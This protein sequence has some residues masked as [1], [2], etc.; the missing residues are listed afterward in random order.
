[1]STNIR[2]KALLVIGAN[3]NPFAEVEF[4]TTKCVNEIFGKYCFGENV[5]RERLSP[6][7]FKSLQETIRQGKTLDSGIA[8]EVAAAML[9][10]ALELGVTHFTHWF[11][12]MTG[13][14]AEKHDC[15]IEP[16]GDGLPIAKFR[17]GELIRGEPDASSFPS[18]G[19]R[20]T[21]EARGYTAW[22]PTSPAFVLKH[23]NGA[24]LVIPTI[25]VSWT[26]EALDKK[27]PLLRSGAALQEQALR[28]LRLFGNKTANRIESTMGAEQEYFLVDRRLAALRPDLL[29]T[30]RTL[31]GAK[32]P[33]GQ[34]LEDNYFG[35]IPE[36]VLKFMTD[37]EKELLDLGVPIKTRH[38]EVAP[39]Q[40]ELAPMF[41]TANLATDHQMLIMRTLKSVAARH[42]FLCVLHEKPFA[43]VNGSGKHNNWSLGTDEGE[44]LLEPG[45]TPGENAQFLVFCTAVLRAVHKY[46]HLLRM[47]VCGA[48]NDHRLGANEAPPAIIS[49]FLGGALDEV[50]AQLA[51]GSLTP[52]SKAAPLEIGVT[53]LPPISRHSGDRNRT[54]PFA[55]TGNKFEFRAVGSSQNPAGST[56]VI[57]TI[58]AESLDYMATKLE[59]AVA[60]G[61]DFKAAVRNLV[62]ETVKEH[63]DI[64]F[65]GDCYS[66]AWKEEAAKRGLPNLVSTVDC[67]PHINSK[68][69]I[70]LF[71]KYKVYSDV[72]LNSR[73]E[74]IGDNY[75]TI[76]NI[77]SSTAVEVASTLILPAA[78]RYKESL[79]KTATTSPQK[80]LLDKLDGQI[81]AL[82]ISLETL[83]AKKAGFPD[84][85]T[86]ERANYCR[87]KILP[88]MLELRKAVDALEETVD[89]DLWPLP[90]YTEMLFAY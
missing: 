76:I 44:N 21:F 67:L 65:S 53:L 36:R 84:G 88:A 3:K 54:S 33:R 49:V 32:P 34:E 40:F 55:F 90:T 27:T 48:G 70:A 19:L 77:E 45:D 78:F 83:R 17:G 29:V 10:W 35:A 56:T 85:E 60:K 9:K 80:G 74:I 47:S 39:G 86:Q 14:T 58:V 24:T 42:G 7:V 22:D 41:E 73:F 8:D 46:G 87:D 20:A 2:R 25:F 38:N 6:K 5:Q 28:I 1:M 52:G 37:V 12:P 64:I 16:R 72:E 18:G 59:A 30:G 15:F 75:I 31:F 11:Q 51:A 79:Q 4:P 50:Y 43:G 61:E 63:K 69:S 23:D 68:E 82:I 81:D 13:S 26:G 62:I 71:S 89:D 66:Q 57:N